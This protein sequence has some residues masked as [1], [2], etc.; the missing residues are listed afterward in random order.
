MLSGH[1]SASAECDDEGD[2]ETTRQNDDGDY[3]AGASNREAQV[4]YCSAFDTRALNLCGV[5]PLISHR[6]LKYDTCRELSCRT[7][8][9]L[10]RSF[11]CWESAGALLWSS[12]TP[13]PI[14]RTATQKYKT[15]SP[16]VDT[17]FFNLLRSAA[18][19]VRCII[20]SN[21]RREKEKNMYVPLNT[22]N[23][24]PL[25]TMILRILITPV[26]RLEEREIRRLLEASVTSDGMLSCYTPFLLA[27]VKRRVADS[28]IKAPSVGKSTAVSRSSCTCGGSDSAGNCGG[29][30]GVIGQGENDGRSVAAAPEQS[31]PTLCAEALWALSEYA[32]LSPT[33]AAA[34]VLPLAEQMAGDELEHPL[35]TNFSI[36]KALFPG[37]LLKVARCT[38][39]TC[40]RSLLLGGTIKALIPCFTVLPRIQVEKEPFRVNVEAW[41]KCV[42]Y[43]V[44]ERPLYR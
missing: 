20:S 39:I 22:S 35:V 31:P 37:S 2:E 14:H 15:P 4:K 16:V 11:Y 12:G 33:L 42:L 10:A 40:Q 41:T 21:P 7:T 1:R 44:V 26:L 23:H 5:V 17:Y 34:E 27:I 13:P 43:G 18:S 36:D 30:C 3:M 38:C 32:V 29:E 25:L 28:A 19:L 8:K 6:N 9:T 24:D